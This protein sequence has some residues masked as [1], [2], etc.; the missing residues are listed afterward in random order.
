MTGEEIKEQR[1]RLEMAFAEVEK[2]RAEARVLNAQADAMEREN[3]GAAL[4]G[5][6]E[7]M[8]SVESVREGVVNH[9]IES[10]VD[11]ID[12]IMFPF[13][14]RDFRA[15]MDATRAGMEAI[16]NSGMECAKRKEA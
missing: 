2:T 9:V 5:A 14:R 7:W 13:A 16:F 12:Q 6:S 1:I 4:G 15:L 3:M 8:R 11:E 10:M